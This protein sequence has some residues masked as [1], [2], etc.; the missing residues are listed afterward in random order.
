MARDRRIVAAMYLQGKTQMEIA[1]KTGRSQPTVN[2]DLKA[3]QEV[4]RIECAYDINERKQMEL[5]RIDILEREYWAAWEKSKEKSFTDRTEITTDGGQSTTGGQTVKQVKKV[6]QQDEQYGDPRY[7][8][9][10]QWCVE[11]RCSI[12]GIDAPKNIDLKSGGAPIAINI[13]AMTPTEKPDLNI[14]EP[15]EAEDASSGTIPG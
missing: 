3:V 12:L 9:G 7:L 15:A 8:A 14:E 2:R 10:V 5:E 1:D 6:T 13:V 11:R 4:W